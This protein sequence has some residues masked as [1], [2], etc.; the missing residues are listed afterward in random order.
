M[1]TLCKKEEGESGRERERR[2]RGQ[3]IHVFDLLGDLLSHRS[4]LFSPPVCRAVNSSS[5]LLDGCG[6]RP[7]IA[8][9]V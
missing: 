7:Y 5:V 3:K 1:R 2:E 8:R 4:L 6:R 9:F